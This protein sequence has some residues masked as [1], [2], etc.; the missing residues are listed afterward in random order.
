[1]PV[2]LKEAKAR[3]Y[4]AFGTCSIIYAPSPATNAPVW[5]VFMR[6]TMRHAPFK[7]NS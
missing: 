2:H 1:M 5:S 6:T 4:G 3:N 7:G